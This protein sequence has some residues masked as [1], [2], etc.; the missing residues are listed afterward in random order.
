MAYRVKNIGL[1]LPPPSEVCEDKH[2]AWHG[3]VR[4]RGKVLK[5]IVVSDKMDKT[6]TVVIPL[7]VKV[8][9]YERFIRK[10]IKI[11]AHNPPCINAR[12]GD[13]VV[14]GET[15]KLSKTKSFVVLAK[16]GR[17]AVSEIVRLAK[18]V[19]EHLLREENETSQG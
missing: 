6:V 15:R 13:I 17:T 4:V 7:V 12:V 16:V 3:E 9:K 5:G 2:C 1:D 10:K 18:K 19:P 14:I 8:P 11:K